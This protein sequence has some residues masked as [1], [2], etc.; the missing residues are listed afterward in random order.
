MQS[1]ATEGEV[2]QSQK[3]GERLQVQETPAMFINGRLLSGA[4]PWETLQTIIKIELSRPADII[5]PGSVSGPTAAQ[6]AAPV[7]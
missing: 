2:E 3:A 1:R 4:L 5:V 6:A 7:K